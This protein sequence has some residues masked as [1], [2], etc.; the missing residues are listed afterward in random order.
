[1]ISTMPLSL[2]YS[3]RLSQDKNRQGC[4]DYN[5][6]V[7]LARNKICENEDK[8]PSIAHHARWARHHHP[9]LVVPLHHCITCW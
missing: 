2:T 6:A 7:L 8:R 4:I 9:R 3:T 1:M 5:S